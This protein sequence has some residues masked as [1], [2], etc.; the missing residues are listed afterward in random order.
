MA[1]RA[2]NNSEIRIPPMV[3]A[4]ALKFMGDYDTSPVWN[5]NPRARTLV[6]DLA[7]WEPLLRKGWDPLQTVRHLPRRLRVVKLILGGTHRAGWRASYWAAGDPV[8]ISVYKPTWGS[9]AAF[10]EAKDS[11]D[12][13]LRH[14]A[15]DLL[16]E[17]TDGY[18]V[19]RPRGALPDELE[20]ELKAGSHKFDEA[21]RREA[22][23]EARPAHA[24][25]SVEFYT[26][27]ADLVTLS[28]RRI[29]REQLRHRFT[30]KE[31]R[32][33]IRREIAWYIQS[34]ETITALKGMPTYRKMI[35]EF[36]SQVMARLEPV[37]SP[38]HGRRTRRGSGS[39]G[40][41]RSRVRPTGR[42]RT[43]TGMPS[44][45]GSTPS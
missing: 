22:G 38:L 19:G 43:S 23:W 34:D 3:R 18:R 13:E 28:T 39:A 15:Q 40:S 4:A 1:R 24:Q 27:L 32:A 14:F 16:S 17:L 11:L 45:A 21:N 44:S 2:R 25:R 10:K 9:P 36:S 37:N 5:P 33:M 7:G 8:E 35:S 12:H 42:T 30:E 26:R 41:P 6:T 29:R 20:R 31:L